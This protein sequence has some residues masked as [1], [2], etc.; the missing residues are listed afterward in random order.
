M[1]RIAAAFRWLVRWFED[2]DLVPLLVIVSAAHYIA[3]LSAVDPWFVALPLGVLVDL[4]HYRAVNIAARYSRSDWRQYA[5]RW[6]VAAG[7]TVISGAYHLRYYGGDWALA[8]PIP[9]LIVALA[10]FRRMDAR[11]AQLR[12]AQR[13]D[14]DSAPHIETQSAAIPAAIMPQSLATV[15]PLCAKDAAF[16]LW[17]RNPDAPNEDVAVAVARSLRTVQLY[18]A[19]FVAG[20]NGHGK[21]AQ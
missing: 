6:F 17:R 18:R 7:L 11:P 12:N 13:T 21:E 1:T 20:R 19:E 5:V 15:A 14:A 8:L 10:Y 4:G 2:G 9:A 3:I 16:A